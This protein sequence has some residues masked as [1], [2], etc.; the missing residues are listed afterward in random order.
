VDEGIRAVRILI[1]SGHFSPD[2]GYQEVRLASAYARAGHDVRVVTTTFV[3]RRIMRSKPRV[4]RPGKSQHD[5]YEIVRLRI[6]LRLGTTMLPIG[7]RRAL[8]EYEPDVVIGIGI[9]KFMPV[10][11]AFWKPRVGYKLVSVFGDAYKHHLPATGSLVDKTVS[12]ARRLAFATVKKC[13]Y[14]YVIRR[15]DRVIV[16]TPEAE[17]IM[18][19]RYIDGDGRGRLRF[20]PLGFDERLFFFDPEERAQ[21]RRRLGMDPGHPVLITASKVEPAKRIERLVDVFEDLAETNP[22]LTWF[23]IGFGRSAYADQVRRRIGS[24]SVRK[25]IHCRPF[26]DAAGL[27]AHYNAA[28]VGV[29]TQE[30]ITIQEAMGTG[31]TVVLPRSDVLSHLLTEGANG[32]LW[33]NDAELRERLAKACRVVASS[34]DPVRDRRSLEAQNRRLSYGRLAEGFTEGLLE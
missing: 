14:L 9:A 13:W 30:T 22:D 2:V 4:Y 25:R 29:W 32:Y 11:A 8:S 5:G 16:T 12:V 15:S 27:R 21:L 23:L 33:E 24:S 7:M 1:V 20:I 3:P 31:L 26:M 17:E 19:S 6:S 18:R 10:M 34:E 28:D